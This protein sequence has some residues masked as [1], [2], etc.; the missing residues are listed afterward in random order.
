MSIE[1]FFPFRKSETGKK[2]IPPK[3]IKAEKIPLEESLKAILKLPSSERLQALKEFK[4]RLLEKQHWLASLY[5]ETLR[6]I[7]ANP[8]ISAEK[9]YNFFSA[10]SE[11]EG[12]RLTDSQKYI[13]KSIFEEYER[14]RGLVRELKQKFPDNIKLFEFLFG[15]KPKGEIE[16][17][18]GPMMLMFRCFDPQDFFWACWTGFKLLPWEKA[19]LK[20]RWKERTL[21]AGAATNLYLKQSKFRRVIGVENAAGHSLEDALNSFKHE[22]EHGFLELLFGQV[23]EKQDKKELLPKI[24]AKSRK[25]YEFILEQCCRSLLRKEEQGIR[26]ELIIHLRDPKNDIKKRNL[27]LR[28]VFEEIMDIGRHLSSDEAYQA[29][30]LPGRKELLRVISQRFKIKKSETLAMLVLMAENTLKDQFKKLLEEAGGALYFL[31]LTGY[32]LDRAITLLSFEP[33]WKWEKTA[34]RIMISWKL[35]MRELKGEDS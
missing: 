21:G 9:L 33:L 28:Q 7:R 8:D 12:I 3:E 15:M 29:K 35:K 17:M 25:E 22:E 1:K 16:V 5:D 30:L 2:E 24:E 14:Q 23:Q 26:E 27:D 32:S 34:K 13:L 11:E 20:K 10:K 31:L 19:S 6:M 18:E 4:K